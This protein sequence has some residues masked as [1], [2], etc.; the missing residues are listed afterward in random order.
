[1]AIYPMFF[2]CN[3]FIKEQ[4]QY[5]P[6]TRNVEEK[7]DKTLALYPCYVGGKR[8]KTLAIYP[9]NFQ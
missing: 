9:T 4:S 5:F 2:K 6:S 1:M 8:D 3:D 7:M